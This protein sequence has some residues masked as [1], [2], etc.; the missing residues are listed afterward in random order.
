MSWG[1]ELWDQF[2]NLA[3]HTQ[4]GI[5][6]LEKYGHFIRDRCHIEKEYAAKLRR[7]VK[8]YQPKKK[9]ED[10]YQY[11][12]C[13]AF[14]LVM[15]EINDLAGQ[16]EVIAENLQS[17][18]IEELTILVKDIREDR[19]KHLNEGAK[20]TNLL[21]NQI[22]SLERSK[23][24]YEK[25]FKESEKAFEN[26]H[27]ADADLNLSRAEIEKYKTNMSIKSQMCEDAK[28]EYANQLQKTNEMQKLHYQ[29]NLPSVLG[30]LQELDEKRIK[31]I[32]NFINSS[33][34]IERNVRPIIEQCI[35]GITRAAEHIDEKEDTQLVI[36]RY[37]SGF[38]PPEDFPFEDLSRT[39][40]VSSETMGSGILPSMPSGPTTMLRDVGLTVRGLSTL[41]GNKN[42]KRVGIFGIFG[43]NKN[44]SGID[45]KDD[46][47]EL[48]PNQ[49]RKKLT[50]K[51]EELEKLIAQK[52]AARDGLM[53][54]K[55]VFEGNPRLG[56]PMTVESELNESGHKLEK[57]REELQR[58]QGYL[59]DLNEALKT[60][61]GS[62]Q[63]SPHGA[64]SH[65]SNGQL[66]VTGLTNGSTKSN[67]NSGGSGNDEDSLSRSASDSSVTNPT[68]N[69]NKTHLT[70]GPESGL[71]TSH[72]SLPNIDSDQDQ[73]DGVEEGEYCDVEQL[74]PLG[75]CR[76]LYP[77]DAT[78][79]GSIPMAENEELYVIELD[80]GDGWTRVRRGSPL[81]EEGFVPTSYIETTIF[82]T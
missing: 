63:G 28:N 48:P 69:H 45:G 35:D 55:G 30:Q 16:H 9:D 44:S 40:G 65:G 33:A 60:N 29:C 15:N 10:E 5:D 3:V 8:S 39:G 61:N 77:F 49:R 76:A 50:Q 22:Q 21:L 13:K 68:V 7:L 41:S 66:K 2:D 34:D 80:Q 81:H 78:S 25:A 18:V 70:E 32:R 6:F 47:S 31:N 17:N 53:K 74:P 20:L 79:D 46:Y 62:L 52:T 26:Y 72:T 4:K 71:G 73:N 57:Y 82:Q 14:K 19:K 12:S 1:N 54:M 51:I 37:K 42:K 75:T 59:A 11:S 58:Y 38:Q 27:K 56:D 64:R 24:A 43:S 67:R 36:D 23:K